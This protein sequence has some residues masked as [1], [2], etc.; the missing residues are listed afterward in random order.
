MRKSLDQAVR[1]FT[2]LAATAATSIGLS[3]GGKAEGQAAGAGVEEGREEGEGEEGE[4]GDVQL[5]RTQPGLAPLPQ[6][7]AAAARVAA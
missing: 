3:L 2:P 7:A 1:P 4:L 5:A 6:A